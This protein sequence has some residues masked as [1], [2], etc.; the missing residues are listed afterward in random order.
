[1]LL[2]L[3]LTVPLLAEWES[4]EVQAQP[5]ADTF[6]Y[7]H[8]NRLV[9]SVIDGVTSTSVYNGD[10]LRMSHTVDGVTTDYIW[11]VA[12]GLPVVLQDSEG[13][14]YVYGLDLISRTGSGGNQEYYSHD[15]LG[16][17]VGLIDEDGDVVASYGYDAFGAIRSQTGSSPNE[18]TF[19]GEQVD[20]TGLQYLRAR[21]YDPSTGRF[22]TRD[23]FPGWTMAPQTMN[24]YAYV[25]NNPVRF[26]DP[27]GLECTPAPWDWGECEDKAE[28]WVGNNVVEP[29]ARATA[30]FLSDPE[31]VASV[32]Q[33]VSGYGIQL[34]CPTVETGVGAV[35][36]GVSIVAYV[37]AT[38]AKAYMAESREEMWTTTVTGGIGFVT[39]YKDIGGAWGYSLAGLSGL[40]DA[41]VPTPATATNAPMT[42]LAPMTPMTPMTPVNA[43]VP[44]AGKE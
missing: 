13:N 5:A 30:D 28:E 11:D 21:Y 27:L 20:G 3:V 42:P 32:V 6:T 29:V 7:D 17:T 22:L 38:G 18:F 34:T 24:R 14:T 41:S 33:V 36:C 2:L 10:G 35:V 43:C 39:A 1:M 15:G 9:E 8:E 23:P 44:P 16:S 31:N 4:P 25:V 40:L 37:G 26:M 19:T 12:A